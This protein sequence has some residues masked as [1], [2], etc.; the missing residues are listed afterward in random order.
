MLE[1]CAQ[2]KEEKAAVA[3]LERKLRDSEEVRSQLEAA[4]NN[5]AAAGLEEEQ[6]ARVKAEEVGCRGC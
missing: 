1:P 6:A 2:V 3:E 5:A 4:A